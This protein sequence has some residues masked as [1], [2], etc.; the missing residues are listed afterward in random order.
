MP[1]HNSSLTNLTPV[2]ITNQLYE[3][4]FLSLKSPA[5]TS[6]C[7]LNVPLVQ[8]QTASPKGPQQ[9]LQVQPSH[10]GSLAHQSHLQT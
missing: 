4:L 9:E 6:Y 3:F 7:S 1:L 8:R 10:L 5:E 2:Y